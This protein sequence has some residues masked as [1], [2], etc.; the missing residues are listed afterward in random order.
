MHFIAGF[1]D[2]PCFT[3]SKVRPRSKNLV[4]NKIPFHLFLSV[5]RSI[6]I[7]SN[8][9]STDQPGKLENSVKTHIGVLSMPTE[10]V[11]WLGGGCGRGTPPAPHSTA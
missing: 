5:L 3:S 10:A 4:Q 6:Q 2:T 9:S 11:Q 8:H 7:F 1:K